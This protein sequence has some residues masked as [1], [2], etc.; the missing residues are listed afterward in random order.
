MSIPLQA[1]N[2]GSPLLKRTSFEV[3]SNLIL[4]SDDRKLEDGTNLKYDQ[5]VVTAEKNFVELL[6]SLELPEGLR[7]IP[8]SSSCGAENKFKIVIKKV[9]PG[10]DQ[11]YPGKA[12]IF[13]F[14]ADGKTGYNESR[15]GIGQHSE[16]GHFFESS[17]GSRNSYKHQNHPRTYGK[18]KAEFQ[19]F[20]Q[21][22]L[23]TVAGWEKEVIE[24]KFISTPDKGELPVWLAQRA[25]FDLVLT[26]GKESIEVDGNQ[27]LGK[28]ALEF[29][30]AELIKA[31][32]HGLGIGLTYSD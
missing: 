13:E 22:V 11:C 6:E 25:V 32:R 21:Y 29:A 1:V 14:N 30:D 24:H 31:V 3:P 27:I 12:A 5:E 8:S 18:L 16:E 23:P 28:D 20:L 26:Q 17:K 19:E 7:I 4:L 15:W 2:L 9:E 10:R